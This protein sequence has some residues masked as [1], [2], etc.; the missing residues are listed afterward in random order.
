M[1]VCVMFFVCLFVF[2]INTFCNS[3]SLAL[4]WKSF[5]KAIPPRQSEKIQAN[6]ENKTSVRPLKTR[7]VQK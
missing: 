1:C 2:L 5:C 3:K 4:K 7:S 6:Q